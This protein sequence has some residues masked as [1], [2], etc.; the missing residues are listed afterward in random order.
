MKNRT[1]LISVYRK[2]GVVDFARAISDMG[3]NLI[4]TGGTSRELKSAGLEV[5]DV[6]EVTGHPECFDG[7][8]KTLHPAIHSGLLS[9]RANKEDQETLNELGYQ[10]IDLVC[11]NLYPFEET[12]A[13]EPPV[14]DPT[15]IEMIDIGG[16]TMIRSAA[17][18]HDDV[19]VVTSPDQYDE[20]LAALGEAKGEP[21]KIDPKLRKKLA[22]QAFQETSAYDSGV[23]NELD[24]RFI[25]EIIPTQSHISTGNGVEL[26]YGE[27]PHQLA[28]FYPDSHSQNSLAAA[29]QL[30]GKPLSFN[31]YLDLD[32][33]LRLVT[34]LM[35]PEFEGMDA[36]VIIK[37]TNPCGA[38]IDATQDGAWANA[39]LSDPESAFGCVIAF[40]KKVTKTTAEVIG[41]HFFECL[42]APDYDEEAIEILSIKKN[43]RM[44]TLPTM[45]PRQPS[46]KMKQIEGGWLAQTQGPPMIDWNS[47]ESVT[48]KEFTESDIMLAKFGTAVISD[49]KSNAILLVSTTKT[50]FATVGV[51]PGQTS[52]VE[53]VRI[54]A[55]RAGDRA[56]GSM[57]ISDAFF[58]FR[59]GID[60][61][62][63]IGVESI[64]QPGGSM[65]DS[66]SI[67]AADEHDMA[68]IFT[69][70]RL[71]L[72]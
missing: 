13:I 30:G 42:L 3:W 45:A 26:R 65:R 46:I 43:R 33:A 66:D 55:R 32:A 2:E 24:S 20:V 50:G 53:A 47:I 7:R 56:K 25:G 22:L 48:K 11:V 72:H 35:L 16:P 37:H 44:L 59:D 31:N 12:A 36:C 29:K 18:N 14:D 8:V 38:S 34:T 39:L 1:A 62:N 70:R 68:M 63:E 5:K 71:F 27:N 28:A 10:T 19:I 69:N 58:P 49:V 67:S 6:S 4:S 23:S 54:A 64:V 57:M 60:T 17:K 41:D 9:R 15:L 40:N 51:G 52:R 21:T 61:A